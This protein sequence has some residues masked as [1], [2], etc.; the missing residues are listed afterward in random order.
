MAL[1]LIAAIGSI[2]SVAG[3]CKCKSSF[4][5]LSAIDRTQRSAV[6]TALQDLDV[7]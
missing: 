4:T 6:S 3:S 2:V 1:S 7:L 5:P